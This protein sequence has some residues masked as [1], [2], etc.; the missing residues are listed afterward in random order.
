MSNTV[1]KARHVRRPLPEAKNADGRP[2]WEPPIFDYSAWIG[3]EYEKQREAVLKYYK[4]DVVKTTKFFDLDVEADLME[5]YYNWI[6]AQS[7]CLFTLGN[8]EKYRFWQN[9]RDEVTLTGLKLKKSLR[10]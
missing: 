6:N 2:L 1:D 7:P 8:I 3:E 10:R 4:G 5:D 9:L